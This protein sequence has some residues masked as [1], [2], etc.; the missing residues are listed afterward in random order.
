MTTFTPGYQGSE[1]SRAEVTVY[2]RNVEN[3]FGASDKAG[4]GFYTFRGETRGN[5][6]PMLVSV[7]TRKIMGQAS[8]TF[9]FEI[10][11]RASD[12]Q[13]FR[14]LLA[15]DDWVDIV[16]SR[17]E[18]R[19]HVMRGL[20]DDVRRL[21]AAPGATTLTYRISGRDFGKVFESTP[22][23]FDRVT[24][25][26][27]MAAAASRIWSEHHD[28]AAGRID[29]TVASL[30]LGFLRPNG[31][32]GS[33]FWELPGSMPGVVTVD[34]S[35]SFANNIIIWNGDF[36]NI[37]ARSSTLYP[38]FFATE[39]QYVWELANSWADLMLCELY[40]DLVRADGGT[41]SR[42]IYLGEDEE[43]EPQD[44]QMAVIIRDRPFPN[45]V[46]DTVLQNSPY[47]RRVPLFTVPTY[48][49]SSTELGRSGRERKNTFFFSPQMFAELMPGFQDMQIPL[50]AIT[51]VDD[52]GMRRLDAFSRY[53][54][55]KTEDSYITMAQDYRKIVRDIHCLNHLFLNGSVVLNH[56]RPDIRIGGRLR[57]AGRTQKEDETFYIEGVYHS[58]DLVNGARTAVDVSRG[59]V[60][61]DQS[62]IDQL[63]DK[64]GEYFLLEDTGPASNTAVPF[65]NPIV[66]FL[67][68]N[69]SA[70]AADSPSSA[71]A[72]TAGEQAEP[73]SRVWTPQVGIL[74]PGFDI[75][76]EGNISPV[77]GDQLSGPGAPTGTVIPKKGF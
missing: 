5:S 70:L 47:F 25:G 57:I 32:H 15:D 50:A 9:S 26:N 65:L 6:E 64:I 69:S 20:I 24:Q 58:W 36:T 7:Q 34:N 10:K 60:G 48:G 44:T 39:N 52:H 42:G 43:I 27:V 4:A 77:S 2:S 3:P 14:F 53:I 67:E 22:F 71:A 37:P 75:D 66:S 68:T 61:T 72:P 51:D 30:L 73:T 40:V 55:T 54:N 41:T 1:T 63:N 76:G 62:L 56:S 33:A 29:T 28:F 74:K 17:H 8:G 59:W 31:N 45:T 38:P 12:D 18:R 16:F 23:W 35:T 21:K 49:V 11:V 46:R 19:F 13:N